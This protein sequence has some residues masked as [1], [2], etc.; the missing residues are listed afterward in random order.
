MGSAL[1]EKYPEEQIRQTLSRSSQKATD[2]AVFLKREGEEAK[3]RDILMIFCKNIFIALNR[4]CRQ[5]VRGQNVYQR[6]WVV[7]SVPPTMQMRLLASVLSR[8]R[9][10]S[11]FTAVGDAMTKENQKDAKEAR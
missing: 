4:L 8:S 6:D 11:S 9:F 10:D 1:E 2:K 3:R 5:S 7:N